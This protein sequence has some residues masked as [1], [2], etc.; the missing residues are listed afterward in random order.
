LRQRGF[1][2]ARMSDAAGALADFTRALALDPNSPSTRARRGWGFLNEASKLA[3]RDFEEAIKL[4]PKNG[5]LYNGRGLARVLLGDCKGAVADVEEALRLGIPG[6]ELR[7]RLALNYNAAC[8]Y[9]QAAAKAAFTVETPE[10]QALARRYQ[11]RAVTLFRQALDLLPA[12]AR[13][14]FIKQATSDSALDPIRAYP[15]FVQLVA[16]PTAKQGEK[17]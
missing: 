5:D 6:N 2:R 1:E 14:L 12:S 15:P 7:A 3:L 11:D 17:P 16:D 8:I 9:A 13:T 10:H 4:D